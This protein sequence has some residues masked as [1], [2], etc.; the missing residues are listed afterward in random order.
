MI[1]ATWGVAGVVLLLASALYRLTPLAMDTF[2]YPL[3]L[4]HWAALIL[5]VVFMAYSEG[6]RGFQRGFAP[7]VAARA[8]YLQEKPTLINGLMAPLFCMALIDAT[9]ARLRA[10]WLLVVAIVGFVLLVQLLDQPWRGMV[11]SG[12]VVGLSWG[13]LSILVSTWRAFYSTTFD[14]PTDVPGAA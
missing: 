7:R 5:V 14:F 8:R 9:P 11:D 12:V 13:S 1:A 4:L 3:S 10:S 6:Y 2:S